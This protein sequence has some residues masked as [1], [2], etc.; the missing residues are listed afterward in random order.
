[1]LENKLSKLSNSA[2]NITTLDVKSPETIRPGTIGKTH[3]KVQSSIDNREKVRQR[4]RDLIEYKGG[5]CERCEGIYHENLFDF[6]HYDPDTKL[7]S[8]GQNNMNR[9]WEKL[10]AEA[11]KCHLLCSNCHRKVHTE[12]D[13]HFMKIK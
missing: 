5:V 3:T 9:A 6:H 1:M 10:V 12:Q 8:V 4:K 13:K 2:A 11:D 7:F